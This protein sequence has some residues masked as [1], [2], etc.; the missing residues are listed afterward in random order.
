MVDSVRKP[1]VMREE[2]ID[3]IN[4]EICLV[5]S[6]QLKFFAIG[7]CNHKSICYMCALRIRIL[8]KDKK[9]TICK[10]ENEEL[11]IA[12]DLTVSWEKF[13]SDLRNDAIEDEEDEGLYYL[14]EYPYQKMRSLRSFI[15]TF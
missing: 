8:L 12:S 6:E 11:L 5:C 13:D 3:L 10:E 9:C 2:D 7:K 15:C 4:F 14:N 1:S